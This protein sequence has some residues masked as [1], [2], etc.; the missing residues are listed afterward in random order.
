MNYNE[1]TETKHLGHRMKN[2]IRSFSQYFF[3]LNFQ[4]D[5]FPQEK[6]GCKNEALGFE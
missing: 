2:P 3:S 1:K 6:M 5:I 4:L